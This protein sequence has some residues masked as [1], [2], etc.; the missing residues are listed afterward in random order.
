MKPIAG[1][2][3]FQ[4]S[5]IA[6][7][8]IAMFE[9]ARAADATD[10]TAERL[11]ILQRQVTEQSARL[12]ELKRSMAQEEAHLNEVKRALGLETLGAQ[13]GRGAAPET[14]AQAGQGDAN[15]ATPVGRAPDSDAR[16]PVV[17]QIFEQPGVLT[18][19]GKAVLEPSLQY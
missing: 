3:L 16:P 10:A 19:K 8:I 2:R 18:P 5:A 1:P 17:A 7:S 13:R 12:D 4:L 9:P 11:Q 14:T 15:P 6:C